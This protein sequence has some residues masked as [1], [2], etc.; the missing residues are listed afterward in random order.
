MFARQIT[1]L[2]CLFLCLSF[3]LCLSLVSVFSSF[4]S[5]SL[6]LSVYIYI[7]IHL[8]LCVQVDAL[9]SLMRVEKVPDATYEMVGGLD[10]QI[11]QIKEVRIGPALVAY[12]LL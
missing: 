8:S 4:L 3:P 1:Q 9:V 2:L 12:L 7:C 6:S 11:K 5:T 10:N